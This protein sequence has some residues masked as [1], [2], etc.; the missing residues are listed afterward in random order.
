MDEEAENIFQQKITTC[1]GEQIQT[2]IPVLNLPGQ[3][4]KQFFN[5]VAPIIMRNKTLQW[6]AKTGECNSTED[7]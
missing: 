7:F 4:L 3:V 2:L 6:F 1:L 5:T